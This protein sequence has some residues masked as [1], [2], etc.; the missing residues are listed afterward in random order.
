MTSVDSPVNRDYVRYLQA[1][2]VEAEAGLLEMSQKYGA[3]KARFDQQCARRGIAPEADIVSYQEL[4]GLHPELGFWYSKVEH[5]QREMAAYGA[6]LTGI[7]AARRMLG[8]ERSSVPAAGR[9][10]RP[11]SRQRRPA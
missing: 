2:L 6:A 10:A 8:S 7:E 11:V 9:Q 3:A 5:F 1:K 4:K